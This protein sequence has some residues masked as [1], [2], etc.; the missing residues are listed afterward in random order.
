MVKQLI[1]ATLAVLVGLSAARA[2]VDKPDLAVQTFTLASGVN[3]RSF[4][5][6]RLL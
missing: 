2:P 5:E 4:S 1:L 3:Q 6:C